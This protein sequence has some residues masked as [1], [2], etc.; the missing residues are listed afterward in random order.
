M[1]ISNTIKKKEWN[2]LNK[3][4]INRLEFI[5]GEQSLFST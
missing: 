2:E 4:E 5:E 1:K 3:K